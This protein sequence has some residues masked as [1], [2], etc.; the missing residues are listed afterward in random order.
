M[1]LLSP[2]PPTDLHEPVL[3]ISLDG[4]ID[5]GEGGAM[6]RR[7]MLDRTTTPLSIADA[8]AL[9]DHRARRP[10][11]HIEDGVAT[12]LE[13]PELKLEALADDRGRDVVLLHGAEPDQGWHAFV[14][15][16]VSVSV[17]LGITLVAGLGAYPAAAPHTRPSRLSC[18]AS[19]PSLIERH[20]FTRASVEV[21]AGIQAAIEQALHQHGIPAIGL[22]AQVPHY[23][24]GVSYPEA[25]AALLDGLDAVA[26]R[27]FDT[28]DLREQ[29]IGT[30]N[31]I[32][33]LIAENDQ[34][35][36]MLGQL[37]ATYDSQL[38]VDP[39]LPTG[40]DLAADFQAFL[41]EQGD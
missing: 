15:E 34:H 12:E 7:Q 35:V 41:R 10:T 6:A 39:P 30:R 28:T 24:T 37:E 27:R 33:R 22:W 26:K 36:D 31:R 18:T 9:F 20:P 8:D 29:A 1:S 38:E 16:V 11:L 4:W 5:A 17:E 2:L 32:D 23:L 40:D 21:P 19:T 25:A 13:W 3:V 14:A